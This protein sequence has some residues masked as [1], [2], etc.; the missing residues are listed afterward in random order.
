MIVS[1]IGF[2]DMQIPNVEFDKVIELDNPKYGLLTEKDYVENIGI[3]TELN[4]K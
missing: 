3:L 1:G 2:G 4:S